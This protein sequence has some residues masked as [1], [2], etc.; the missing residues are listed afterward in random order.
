MTRPEISPGNCPPAVPRQRDALRRRRV[1]EQAPANS[2]HFQAY[3]VS[4]T[5][6]GPF[7]R[8]FHLRLSRIAR[9]SVD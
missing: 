5:Y 9:R 1:H 8:G 2:G 6:P 7:D 4:E 3:V